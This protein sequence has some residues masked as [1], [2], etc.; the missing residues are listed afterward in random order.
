VV[1]TVISVL[2]GIL[3]PALR[4]AKERTRETICKTHLKNIGLGLLVYLQDNNYKTADSSGTNGFF[5]YD[6]SGNLRK[7]DD[8]D[9]YW[10]VAYID[11]V[12]DTKV[13]GCPSFRNVAELIYDVEPKLIHESAFGLNE[14]ITD[15]KTTDIR[16]HAEVIVC[17]GHTEPKMEQDERDMFHN[18]D[19]PGAMNLTDYREG[20]RRERFY[21]G[22]FIPIPLNNCAFNIS[23]SADSFNFSWI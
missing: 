11:Y 20:G 4:K 12:K 10:G 22:I 6:S 13:F 2:M 23:C 7:T 18:N 14:Y 19:T 15:R 9:A 21:R 3:L 1:I 17:H 8:R 16:N 5:W